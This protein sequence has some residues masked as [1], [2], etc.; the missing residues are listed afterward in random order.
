MVLAGDGQGQQGGGGRMLPLQELQSTIHQLTAQ[1][2][3]M[4]RTLRPPQCQLPLTAKREMWVQ[5]HPTG[6]R[7]VLHI[8]LGIQVEVSRDR[9][10]NTCSTLGLVPALPQTRQVYDRQWVPL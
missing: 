5:D 7:Y 9:K 2:N 3:K 6:H 1:A 4:L 8:Y 10:D